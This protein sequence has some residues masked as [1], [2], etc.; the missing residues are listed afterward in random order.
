VGR[1]VVEQYSKASYPISTEVFLITDQ[2]IKAVG[3]FSKDI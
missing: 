1:V 2:G 3:E